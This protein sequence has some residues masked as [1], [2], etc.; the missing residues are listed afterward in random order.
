MFIKIHRSYRT[1][2]AICD[3]EILGKK[4]EESEKQLN[5]TENFY[6]DKEV[7]EEGV[8]KTI[9]LQAAEDAT[10]NIVGKNSINA[11]IKSGLIDEEGVGYIKDIPYV[12]V[13]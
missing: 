11:A 4:F 7:S 10:F 6:K 5:L 1:V 13:F 8:I 2:V 9:Q 12:L 3:S